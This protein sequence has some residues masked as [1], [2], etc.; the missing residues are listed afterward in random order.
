MVPSAS[1]FMHLRTGIMLLSRVLKKWERKKEKVEKVC[2]A[3]RNRSIYDDRSLI[4]G[5][6]M[7]T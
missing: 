4:K 2:R 3:K 5:Q 6:T 1:A 7:H